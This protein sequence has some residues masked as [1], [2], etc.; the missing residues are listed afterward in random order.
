MNQPNPA[1]PGISCRDPSTALS[2]ALADE[3][4]AQ[5]GSRLRQLNGLAQYPSPSSRTLPLN[6]RNRKKK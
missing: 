3:N 5:E 6:M 2:P 4:G 1:H